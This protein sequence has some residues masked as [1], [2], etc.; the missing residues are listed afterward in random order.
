ME[1]KG[2]LIHCHGIVKCEEPREK[3]YKEE[4]ASLVF[5]LTKNPPLRLEG[6]LFFCAN[7]LISSPVRSRDR[8]LLYKLMIILKYMKFNSIIKYSNGL[9]TATCF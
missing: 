1:T 9:L 8:S 6:F 3:G 4:E 7:I 2:K 5:P